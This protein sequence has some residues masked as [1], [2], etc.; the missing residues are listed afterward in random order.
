MSG[1][2]DNR[3]PGGLY[4]LFFT[5]MWERFSYYGMRALL[6]LYLVNALEVP[7]AEAL[8]IYATYTALVY[9]SPILGGYLADRWLGI[10]RAVLVGAMVMA[11]GHFAMAVPSL[12][13]PALG[14]LIAGNGFFK[15]NISTLVGRL[16]TPG[17]ARRDSGFTI[18]Y[19]GINLGA[20]L[21]PLVCGT[22]GEKLGWHYGFAAAGVGML[23]GLTVFALGQRR[24]GA[25]GLAPG[26]DGSGAHGV[27]RGDWTVVGVTTIATLALVF[28]VL[29][30]WAPVHR[31]WLALAPSLRGTLTGAVAVAVIGALALLLARHGR[32]ERQR[33]LAIFVMAFFVVFFWMGF[34]QAGGTMNLF[35][36]KLTNRTVLGW[37]FPATYFQ[38]LNPLF[39]LI[40]APLFSMLWLRLDRSRYALASPA[41]QG[42]GM[43]I[44]GLGFVVLAV[45]Q[46]R[47]DAQGSVG[48]QWLVAVY[49]IHTMGELCLSPI[50]LSMVTKLAPTAV[51]SLMMGLW[52]TA[53]AAANYLAGTMEAM[54]ADT[55][56]PLYW[57]L[58]AS[59]VGAGAILLL[60]TPW[61]R[62]LMHGVT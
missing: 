17:D 40:L 14:L 28:A 62:R 37:E 9:L 57:F 18:F 29:E 43:V 1:A 15:P 55:G 44:L 48:P 46:Q 34:E 41:K 26:A 54:L 13:Y 42:L 25:A 45:A 38:A 39:I 59:S 23:G 5:E 61:L 47:A 10:R 22:L 21:A 3:H 20:F 16:Y 50:G 35:A 58:V 36:D 49:L 60:L 33:M 27:S 30:A 53:V 4:P 56:V 6:V 2:S 8:E 12:L 11:L 19:M 32:V 31:W 52:F 24:L 7:R 51:A